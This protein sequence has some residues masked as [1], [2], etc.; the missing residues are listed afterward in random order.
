MSI[1]RSSFSGALAALAMLATTL[2]AGPA[3]GQ[4]VAGPAAS[5]AGLEAV[6]AAQPR[7]MDGALAAIR[8]GVPGRTELFA[9]LGAWF[10]YQR[11]FLREVD[12]AAGILGERFGADGRVVT[13]ANSAADPMRHPLATAENLARAVQA[14]AA[15]MNPEDVL[16]V[17]LTS[18]GERELLAGGEEGSG[19]PALQAAEL[20]RILDEAGAANTVAVIS[21]CRSGSFVPVLSA[22]DRLVVTA[23]A[24]DRNSFGCSDANEWTWF[25]KAFFDEA[26]RQTRSLPQAFGR[27][28]ALVSQW[29]QR[30]QEIPSLPQMARGERIVGA[31]EKLARDA[32]G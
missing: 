26:L 20:D 19:L 28:A 12:Q 6:H 22:P 30:E 7:M 11:V 8:P 15:Q 10:P 13:L 31:L 2:S 5:V 23:A 25:G 24:A 9:V 17:Y 3:A 21:A 18:H 27:A 32:G 16:M 4:T 14:V 1:L 29:E